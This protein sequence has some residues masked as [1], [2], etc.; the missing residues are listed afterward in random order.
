MRRTCRTVTPNNSEEE[1]VDNNSTMVANGGETGTQTELI[2]PTEIASMGRKPPTSHRKPSGDDE[3]AFYKRLVIISVVMLAIFAVLITVIVGIDRHHQ[4]VISEKRSTCEQ[5]VTKL[6]DK[7]A[8]YRDLVGADAAVANTVSDIDVKDSA[9]VKQLD[10]QLSA[11]VPATVN[12]D[13]ASAADLD[14]RIAQA[15]EASTWYDEHTVSLKNAID[16]V[17]KS[18]E[19]KQVDDAHDSLETLLR[20][21]SNVLNSAKGHVTSEN[22]WNDLSKLIGEGSAM[23]SEEDLTKINSYVD[24]LNVKINEVKQSNEEKLRQ[25]E[26]EKADAAKRA[27]E[28]KAAQEKV[29][30]E[31]AKQEKKR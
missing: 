27:A 31:K 13:V 26:Q 11:E 2:N 17:N 18:R 28:Q 8:A 1:N 29:A 5:S 20:D 10:A 7:V 3:H 21:A 12:C 14:N 15:A 24:D 16:E 4:S 25:E 19:L 23:A 9:V 30:Q 22:V 6:D